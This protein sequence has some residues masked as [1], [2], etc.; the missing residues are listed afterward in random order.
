MNYYCLACKTLHHSEKE[1]GIILKA[2][3][4]FIG[5]MKYSIG[6]CNESYIKV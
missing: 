5:D 3:Y 6:Y 2:G 1:K 4:Q